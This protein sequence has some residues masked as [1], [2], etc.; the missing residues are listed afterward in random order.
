[1]VATAA[2]K[3]YGATLKI[4]AVTVGEILNFGDIVSKLNTK[5]VSAHDSG[6]IEQK[7]PVGVFRID[8]VTF[9]LNTLV[10]DAGQVALYAAYA[11]RTKST[12]TVTA[13]PEITATWVF[14]GYV[15]VWDD[16]LGGEPDSMTRK[17]TI[18]VTGGS[19][20]A[21]GASADATTIAYSDSV[22]VKTSLPVFASAT[23][24]PYTLTVN[25]ASGYVLVTVTDATAV[26][27]TAQAT[28][29]GV[30][31]VVWNLTTA[32]QSGQIVIGA[33]ATTT[34]LTITVKDSGK[35]LKT[36]IIYVVRP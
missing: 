6:G 13:P 36:Y 27:I 22:G 19:V 23:Y 34:L 24:G 9:E 14:D 25:T 16:G 4:G 2:I 10:A 12:F 15:T 21:I 35:V 18:D 20:I 29:A 17:V 30:A 8:P 5:D 11:G 33:A 3:S 32:V 7:I 28:I 1:M 26:A 31:G